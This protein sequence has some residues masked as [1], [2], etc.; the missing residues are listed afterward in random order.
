M[1]RHQKLELSGEVMSVVDE[2]TCPIDTLSSCAAMFICNV[3]RRN[4]PVTTRT[5]SRSSHMHSYN[6][7]ILLQIT[8]KKPRRKKEKKRDREVYSS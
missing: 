7:L 5:G 6:V 1:L 4:Y 8:L 2:T 3:E